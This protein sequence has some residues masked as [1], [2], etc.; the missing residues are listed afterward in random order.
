MRTARP[1]RQRGA[2]TLV[3]ALGLLVAVSGLVLAVARTRLTEQRLTGND[4]HHL[5]EHLAAQALL[6]YGIARLAADAWR[7]DWPAAADGWQRRALAVPAGLI[8]TTAGETV[9]DLARRIEA[10]A[11]IRVR[12]RA[13]AVRMEQWVRPLGILSPAGEQAPPLLTTG[14]P[15]AASSAAIYPRGANGPRPA[16]AVWSF[17]GA[18][19][20][21]VP[22]PDLHG[23]GVRLR[24]MPR[25]G[26]WSMLFSVD[27]EAFRAL[28]DADADRPWSQ[29]RYV[30]A[31]AGDLAA[32]AW[33]RS[34]GSSARPVALVFPADLGC[35]PLGAGVRITG[36]VFYAGDCSATETPGAGARITG[37][38]VF[39]GRPGRLA[40]T[41]TLLH[42]SEAADPKPVLP[43]PTLRAPRLPGSWAD[44]R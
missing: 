16:A 39:A 5:R 13:G 33:R 35:P 29:R 14:C 41:A 19:C 24:E 21:P 7:L 20:R 37:T 44:F 11:F 34:L 30:R 2:A 43:F 42:V 26:L 22:W 28:A 6:E 15:A 10:P 8:D 23:G 25:D 31:A 4:I 40:G 3:V 27:R 38:L 36:V 18:R 12:S 1:T 17:A 32:G 9:I